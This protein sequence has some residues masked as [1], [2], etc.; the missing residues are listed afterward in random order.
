MPPAYG[1]LLRQ[2]GFHA[3]R[4]A[5]WLLDHR[6]VVDGDAGDLPVVLDGAGVHEGQAHRLSGA[7]R[8]FGRLEAEIDR[9][10]VQFDNIRRGG[11]HRNSLVDCDCQTDAIVALDRRTCRRVPVGAVRSPPGLSVGLHALRSIPAVGR[12]RPSRPARFI[13]ERRFMRDVVS[14]VSVE[15]Y[16]SLI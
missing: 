6:Q 12:D 5:R 3:R 10:D 13:S 8:Q 14:V 15:R 1:W 4:E 7:N 9:F 2:F 11:D 16:C